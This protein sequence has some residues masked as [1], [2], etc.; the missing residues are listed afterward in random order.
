MQPESVDTLMERAVAGDLRAF[1]EAFQRCAPGVFHAARHL[2]G[3]DQDAEEILQDVMLATLDALPDL[4]PQQNLRTWLFRLAAQGARQ[5][6]QARR[7][8]T[9][10]SPELA[11]VLEENELARDLTPWDPAVS[12]DA[13]ELRSVLHRALEQVPAVPRVIFWLREV[14][15]FD[16]EE[17]ADMLALSEYDAATHLLRARLLLRELLAPYFRVEAET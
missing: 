13:E 9:G 7:G 12:Y 2:L 1:A 8:P 16:L 14:E 11:A 5:K 15:R 4:S 10:E 17:T 6:L 3:D